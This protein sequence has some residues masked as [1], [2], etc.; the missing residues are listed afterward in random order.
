MTPTPKIVGLDWGTLLAGT[1]GDK[2]T[3]PVKEA[4]RDLSI[5]NP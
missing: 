3:G 4:L 1:N 2:K 5:V